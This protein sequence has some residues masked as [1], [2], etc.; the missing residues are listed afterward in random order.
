[1]NLWNRRNLS[2]SC[3]Q[4]NQIQVLPFISTSIRNWWTERIRIRILIH[5][6]KMNE[7]DYWF[8][9]FINLGKFEKTPTFHGEFPVFLRCSPL[10]SICSILT[11]HSEID[12]TPNSLLKYPQ[13]VRK[14]WVVEDWKG[15]NKI[16]S[17]CELKGKNNIEATAIEIGRKPIFRLVRSHSASHDFSQS[18]PIESFQSCVISPQI[19]SASSQSYVAFDTR[20]RNMLSA[21]SQDG[22]D[23]S[24]DYDIKINLSIVWSVRRH[25]ICW[26]DGDRSRW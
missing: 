17:N 22:F 7:E 23:L 12:K 18:P 10:L 15:R 2:S 25:E 26:I 16:E 19:G 8:G 9:T 5:E 1:M 20:C 21:S 4:F 6:A 14:S 13:I 11:N 3:F 24:F